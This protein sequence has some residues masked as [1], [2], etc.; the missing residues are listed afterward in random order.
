MNV[1]FRLVTIAAMLFYSV[2]AMAQQAPKDKGLALLTDS[3]MKA[4]LNFL[5]SDY[6]EGRDTFD[7]GGR[8]AAEY[9][10]SLLEMYGLEPAGDLQNDGTRSYFQKI[11]YLVIDGFGDSYLKVISKSGTIANSYSYDIEVFSSQYNSRKVSGDIVFAGYGLID[12][13][14]NHNDFAKAN[15][16]GKVVVVLGGYPT[17]HKEYF[18]KSGV[19]R[20]SKRKGIEFMEQNGA[21]AIITILDTE[22]YNRIAERYAENK[23]FYM[24]ENIRPNRPRVVSP[25][26]A[27]EYL[28]FISVS[29][30][31]GADIFDG[32]MSIIDNYISASND[33]R[34]SVPVQI[35]GKS[36]E[37]NNDVKSTL[38]YA[39]NVLAV[40]KG[41][42]SSKTFV[43][44]AHYDHFGIKDGYIWNGADDNASGVIGVT[45][46]AAAM[47]SNGEKPKYDVLFGA[48][49]GEEINLLGSWYFV[50]NFSKT[51]GYSE[52]ISNVNFDML[53]RSYTRD[54]TD[55][56]FDLEYSIGNPEYKSYTE[57]NIKEYDLNVTPKF[58]PMT[59][60]DFSGATDYIPFLQTN[61]SFIGMY[62]GHHVDYHMPSDEIDKL[63]YFK[64]YDLVKL[65]Y[66]CTYDIVSNYVEK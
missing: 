10:S 20:S 25:L 17:G 45:S 29:P 64:F 7:K 65:G 22:K 5:S 52:L 41:E 21:L 28:D 61:R 11:P 39:Y 9:I 30:R 46:T 26:T 38:K 59:P 3:F 47:A 12:D 62:A 57:N 15:L 31:V 18:K 60:A 55:I 4:P 34:K 43:V 1:F 27:P 53:S 50:N 23:S 35:K 6:M 56:I 2:V 49:T 33:G 54:T 66:L 48:W 13:K 37:I 32:D 51:H 58:N 14:I 63:L 24:S 44:G 36:I 8:L 19:L 42:D 40:L 16:E